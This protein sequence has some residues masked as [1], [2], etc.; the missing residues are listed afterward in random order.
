M[1][2]RRSERMMSCGPSLALF[3]PLEHGEI[4]DPEETKILRGIAAL[5]KCPMPLG[6]LLSQRQAQQTRSSVNRMIVLLDLRFHTA[7]G[8]VLRQLAVPGNNDDQVVRLSSGFSANLGRGFW[9][10]FLQPFEVF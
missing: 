2:V 1:L 8:F 5:L 7:L 3:V 10:V 9:K 6:I 4:G